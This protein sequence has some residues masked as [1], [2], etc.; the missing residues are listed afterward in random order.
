MLK[1]DRLGWAA[2]L[3][4]RAYGLTIGVRTNTASILE[5]LVPHL[6][7]GW[8]VSGVETVDHLFS[9]LVGHTTE[10]ATPSVVRRVGPAGKRRRFNLLYDG[11]LLD[12]RT[13]DV[14]ELLERF[15][16]SVRL[17][18]A[19]HAKRRVFVHAGVVGWRGRAIVVPGRSFSGKTSLVAAMVRAG[20]TYLSDEYA[21]FDRRGH[22]FPYLKPLS[23]RLGD[24]EK[25]THVP[26]EDL[27]GVASAVPLQVGHVIATRFVEGASWRPRNLTEGEA[28]LA[29]LA[30]TVPARRDPAAVLEVLNRVARRAVALKGSRGDA[31]EAAA[32]ILARVDSGRVAR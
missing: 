21:V 27:G 4:F 8:E 3:S 29:M 22:V 6:P 14:E 17:K 20:A 18:V 25:Q 24:D 7:Y 19:E 15:E 12:I 28:V 13:L 31:D 2:G 1:L 10:H 23:L 32:E 16:S 26:V 11:I 5:R 9:M 30:H